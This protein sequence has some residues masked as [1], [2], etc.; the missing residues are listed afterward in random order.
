LFQWR[1]LLEDSASSLTINMTAKTP[2]HEVTHFRR[3]DSVISK[4]EKKRREQ[5]LRLY[6]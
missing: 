3:H 5:V 4:K 6:G 2:Q 1:A